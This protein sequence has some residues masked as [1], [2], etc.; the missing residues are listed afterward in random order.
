MDLR[1]TVLNLLD[2]ISGGEL[3]L[4]IEEKINPY[5]SYINLSVRVF[6]LSQYENYC[7]FSNVTRIDKRT[8]NSN[9]L[10]KEFKDRVYIDLWENVLKYLTRYNKESSIRDFLKKLYS[11]TRNKHLNYM[12]TEDFIKDEGAD[13]NYT[14]LNFNKIDIEDILKLNGFIQEC[15]YIDENISTTIYSNKEKGI[16]YVIELRESKVK[17]NMWVLIK[18]YNYRTD[19]MYKYRDV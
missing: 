3:N 7:I 4:F 5:R 18:N 12:I 15:S 17:N 14:S 8:Y 1:E 6:I 10:Y 11:K 2:N 13:L 19:G 9:K 16:K